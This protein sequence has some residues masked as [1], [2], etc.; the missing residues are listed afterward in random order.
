[1]PTARARSSAIASGLSEATAAT[2][3]SR[4]PWNRSRMACRLVPAPEAS[5]ATRNGS[6]TASGGRPH[7][8]ELRELAAG[9][10][11]PSRVDQLVNVAE[12]LAGGELVEVAVSRQLVVAVL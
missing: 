9:R 4:P 1:M 12:H 6:L 10:A 7:D 2:S 11:Q 5:T 8:L 3:T